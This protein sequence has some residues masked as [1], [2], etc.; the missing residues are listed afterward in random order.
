[1]T[2]KRDAKKV[3]LDRWMRLSVV[4]ETL[5]LSRRSVL[6]LGTRGILD[7]RKFGDR[8]RVRESTVTAYIASAEKRWKEQP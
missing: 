2:E 4:M 7:I 3:T 6:R 8:W 1:M 5:D